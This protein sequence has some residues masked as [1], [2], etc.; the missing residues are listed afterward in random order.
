MEVVIASHNSH[1]VQELRDGLKEIA[2]KVQVLSLF[3]FPAYKPDAVKGELFEESAKAK[4]LHAAMN[5]KKTCIADESG[6]VVPALD[7][8]GKRY[9]HPEQSAKF[10]TKKLLLL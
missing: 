5:L 3:D 6:I 10:Q 1:K 8:T 2:P 9:F 7:K 4:A